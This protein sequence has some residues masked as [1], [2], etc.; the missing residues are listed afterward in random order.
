MNSALQRY[1]H[2]R[3]VFQISGH[4]F[5]VDLTASTDAVFLPYTTSWGWATWGRAWAIFDHSELTLRKLSAD[6]ALRS[7]FDLRGA[8]PYFDMLRD[9]F[10]GHVN[11]WAI[12]WYASVFLQNGLTLHPVQTLVSNIGFDG[13]GTHCGDNG[14]SPEVFSEHPFR[15]VA[16]PQ[17]TVDER[18]L[19]DISDHLRGTRGHFGYVR[20]ALRRM[21]ARLKL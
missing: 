10:S 19:K 6:S 8:Y 17:V 3:Q 16:Y 4:M 2:E 12:R 14:T 18:V 7:R 20:G 1:E 11:S 13:T 15:V 9:H 21:V 5:P